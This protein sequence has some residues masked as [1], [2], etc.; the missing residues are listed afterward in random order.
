MADVDTVAR[1]LG[2]DGVAD[3]I[4]A[5]AGQQC[6]LGT[7]LGGRHRAGCRHAAADL[8]VVEGVHLD[9]LTRQPGHPV[10]LI[11]HGDTEEEDAGHGG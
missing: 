2:D 5:D 1:Q 8:G 9:R 11:E 6:R 4:V 10:D 3:G 7:E